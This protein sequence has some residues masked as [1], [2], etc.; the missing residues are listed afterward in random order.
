[1][2]SFADIHLDSGIARGIVR[3][4]RRAQA[5]AYR[6]MSPTIMGMAVRIL[7]DEGLAQEV[8]QDTFVELIDKAHTLKDPAA[9]VAWVRRVAVN[10]CYMRLRSPWHKRRSPDP[11]VPEQLDDS[12]GDERL[13]GYRDMERALAVLPAETRLVI[14]LHDV[15]GYTHREIGELTGQTAS[16]SKSQL[17]RGYGKLTQLLRGDEDDGT[18]A[19][20]VRPACSP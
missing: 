10:H 6:L 14:W 17:A 20:T 8:V 5:V 12:N 15:E 11:E 18:Q 1:M 13:Q 19:D 4:D 3:G 9:L 16:Y 7:Q 2:A